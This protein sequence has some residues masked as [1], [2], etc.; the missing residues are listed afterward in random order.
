MTGITL[1][2]GFQAV[3]RTRWHAQ[4]LSLMRGACVPLPATRISNLYCAHVGSYA[5]LPAP[6]GPIKIIRT[7]SCC[8][9]ELPPWPDN[10]P[11]S[12]AMRCSSL[13]TV[14][15]SSSTTVSV[16]GAIEPRCEE[17]HGKVWVSYASGVMEGYEGRNGKSRKMM[18]TQLELM[19]R[20]LAGQALG[21]E[22]WDELAGT[23]RT[24]K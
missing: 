24:G 17:D 13:W 7:L 23:A 8:A 9:D 11:S 18:K 12:S 4:N 19:L 15:L 1:N 20:T 16:M 6:G 2:A 21:P 5:V 10:R 22:R 3:G 14:L